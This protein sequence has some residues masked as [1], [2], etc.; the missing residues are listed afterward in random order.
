MNTLP[1]SCYWLQ[2]KI[3]LS[4]TDSEGFAQ[5]YRDLWDQNVKDLAGKCPVLYSLNSTDTL[6]VEFVCNASHL[7]KNLDMSVPYIDSI[8]IY[9]FLYDPEVSII[10]ELPAPIFNDLAD[11]LFNI[12][13]IHHLASKTKIN[14]PQVWA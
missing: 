3:K 2:L 10:E 14:R 4:M 9:Y 13:S 6:A 12:L 11:E 1:I 5:V 8:E 7:L